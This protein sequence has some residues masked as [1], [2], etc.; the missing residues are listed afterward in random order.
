MLFTSSIP[1]SIEDC[2][3]HIPHYL[4]NDINNSLSVWYAKSEITQAVFQMYPLSAPPDGFTANFFQTHWPIIKNEIYDFVL[5][6]LNNHGSLNEVNSTFI[7]LITKVKIAFKVG[8]FRT[9]GL[10]NV[11]YK[12]VANFIVNRLK[13]ILPSII[14]PAQSAFV[15]HY[16]IHV[17]LIIAYETLHY[18]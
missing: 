11:I 1:H 4:T 16:L 5:N 18:L 13:S 14:S 6:V 7:T 9:I 15:P 10:Y 2:L 12:I 3:V 17:N 8:E